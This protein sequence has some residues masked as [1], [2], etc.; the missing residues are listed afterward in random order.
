MNQIQQLIESSNP[1]K[2]L[3][4]DAAKLAKK[5][6]NSGLLKGLN[7]ETEKNNMSLI[8]ENQAKQLLTENTVTSGGTATF[9]AGT[10]ENWSGIA[11]PMVRKIFGQISA[12]EFLSVQ[13]MNIPSG[14]VFYL[15]FQYGNSKTPFT[16]GSSLYGAHASN[17]FPFST[18][19]PTGG[20]YGAGRFAFSTNQF[21]ASAV[22]ATITSASWAD[23]GFD[24][25]LSS[26]I[27]GGT[28]KKLA[29]SSATASVAPYLDKEGVRAFIITSGSVTAAK[30]F[31]AFTTYVDS[32]DTLSFFVS[33][34]T[35]EVP[36]ANAFVMHYNKLTKDNLRGDFED[37]STHAIPNAASATD[38]VIPAVDIK[39]R[40]EAIVAKTKK[41][42]A[43][44]TPEFSQ[45]L[46]A[47]QSLDAEAE[48]TSIISEYI[49]LEIDL[50]LID[51]MILDAPASNTDYWTAE[52]NMVI[53]S[54]QTGFQALTSG[55]Y[56]SQGQW[57]QTL[58]TKIQKI[59]NKIHQA[60]LRGGANFMMTS[61]TV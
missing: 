31:Q 24:S 50:E 23:V 16:A 37:D 21:S 58:G 44:W 12:K 59:S 19:S 48:L 55:F 46:N 2:S 28:I 25:D 22:T 42:K 39:M 56:N 11:L 3:Q 4:G 53:N 51:M 6:A 43:Q 61:P 52:N 8:L 7:S 17:Q 35:A 47:Y 15:D 14:L 13:P 27:V 60:T 1:W 30:N 40:S 29:I 54:T 36:T 9:T 32:T 45:D 34:S 5:W 38:I 41:L 33:A 49:S 57:F 10:G 20:L 26:S 18:T